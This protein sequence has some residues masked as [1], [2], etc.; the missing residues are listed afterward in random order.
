MQSVGE[1]MSIGR[2]FRESLQKAFRSLEVGLDGLE[3]KSGKRPLDMSKLRFGTAF[4]LLKIREAFL[5]GMSVDEL[6]AITHIDPWFLRHIEILVVREKPEVIDSDSLLQLK[7]EGFSDN[8]IGRMFE[9][10]DFEVR[11]LRKKFNVIPTYKVVDTC[12]AEFKAQTPYC[13]STYEEENEISSLNGK[14]VIILG[15]GPNRIGQGI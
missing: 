15:G 7:Q 12:A 3:P 4:R 9:L 6:Q 1:A 13:Y 10:K 14:K 5:Q 2:T 8:Q 11:E